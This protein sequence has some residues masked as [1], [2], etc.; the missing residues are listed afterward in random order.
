MKA[1]EEKLSHFVSSRACALILIA[2][3]C[4]SAFIPMPPVADTVDATF[5]RGLLFDTSGTW[6]SDPATSRGWALGM[7]LA[8]MVVM[9]MI[10]R[11]YNL[12]R[13]ITWLPVAMFAVMQAASPVTLRILTDAQ[14]AAL[15]M[16]WCLRL[17]YTTY[18]RPRRTK[19]IFMTFCLLS[20]GSMVQYGFLLFIPVMLIGCVQMR[21]FNIRSIAAALLGAVT[22]WW[23]VFGLDLAPL[24]AFRLPSIPNP[25]ADISLTEALQLFVAPA[26]TL[27]AG[28]VCGCFN[29]V[30]MITMK[31]RKRALHGLLAIM[32]I[33]TGIGALADFTNIDFY[34][35]LLNACVAFQIGH[36]FLV[37]E[38]N[39]GYIGILLLIAA[40]TSIWIWELIV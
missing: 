3:A 19:K 30:K 4:V 27:L 11:R 22:P 36:I 1:A 25:L 18:H 33:M 38:D 15:L 10:N 8:T 20:A 28:L 37:N 16:L 2:L 34:I 13:G 29:L 7:M 12:I 14:P 23:I 35:P 17:M 24:S 32:S 40:Y 26:L 21:V 5:S 39:R 9:A 31:A 6:I